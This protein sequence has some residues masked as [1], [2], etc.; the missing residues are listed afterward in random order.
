MAA[1]QHGAFDR[2][3]TAAAGSSPTSTRA[4]VSPAGTTPPPLGS[5]LSNPNSGKPFS[6]GSA[7]SPTAHPR[8][9]S[10]YPNHSMPGPSGSFPSGGRPSA[11]DGSSAASTGSNPSRDHPSRHQSLSIGR[12]ER[13]TP[14]TA[15]SGSFHI[16][17]HAPRADAAGQGAWRVT[18]CD[19]LSI[20][21]A[22]GSAP[23]LPTVP[24]AARANPSMVSVSRA[25]G[26]AESVLWT[27]CPA[28]G[29]ARTTHLIPTT[30]IGTTAL[31]CGASVTNR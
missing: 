30:R 5:P 9:G 29:Q 7:P 3:L 11:P 18:R 28:A 17:F 26:R 19:P 12:S 8:S 22:A 25:I 21:S 31:R 23:A 16:P 27:T 6:K 13:S 24:G 20:A 10:L 4:A 1:C 15:A 14:A 2:R